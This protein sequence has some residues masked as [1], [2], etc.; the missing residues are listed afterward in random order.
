MIGD[1]GILETA[2]PPDIINGGYDGYLRKLKVRR[3]N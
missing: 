2:F 1:D 3:I